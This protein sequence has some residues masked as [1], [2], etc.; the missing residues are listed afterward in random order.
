MTAVRRRVLAVVDLDPGGALVARRAWD[1][2]SYDGARFAL[3]HLMD[4]GIGLEDGYSPLTP[5]EVYAR[6][7]VV[8]TRRLDRMAAGIGA[9]G[10]ATT[11]AAPLPGFGRMLAGWQPDLVVASARA[12]LVIDGHVEAEDWACDGLAVESPSLRRP[13]TDA[14]RRPLSW[15]RR[16]A[17]RTR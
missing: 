12:G 13:W 2:A 5:A 16:P 8:V 10:R 6:L 7:A 3:A 14:L 1:L 4:W 11:L 17:A 9:A 15:P